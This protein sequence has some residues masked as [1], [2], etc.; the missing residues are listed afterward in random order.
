M[1]ITT[2]GA[3][4]PFLINDIAHMSFI[5]SLMIYL[6]FFFTSAFIFG[7][8]AGGIGEAFM[9]YY[10]ISLRKVAHNYP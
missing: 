6:Y 2:L 5:Y 3:N 8:F 10:T 4:F 7:F 9:K 1:L